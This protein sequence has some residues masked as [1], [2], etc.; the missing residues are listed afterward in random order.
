MEYIRKSIYNRPEIRR[1]LKPL[2]TVWILILI[3]LL[4]AAVFMMVNITSSGIS[5]ALLGSNTSSSSPQETNAGRMAVSSSGNAAANNG[6]YIDFF[7]IFSILKLFVL[8]RSS[9]YGRARGPDAGSAPRMSGSYTHRAEWAVYRL[10][11]SLPA[12]SSPYNPS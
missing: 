6:R 2:W 1:T 5:S 7:F 8:I 10:H 4:C 9:R 3:G 11:R 12:R